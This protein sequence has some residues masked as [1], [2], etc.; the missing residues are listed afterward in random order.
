MSDLSKA[1]RDAAW[2][3]MQGPAWRNVTYA[4]LREA[5]PDTVMRSAKERVDR[6]VAAVLETLARH[7]DPVE[8]GDGSTSQALLANTELRRLAAEVFSAGDRTPGS[9]IEK[10]DRR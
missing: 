7:C 8:V 2:A 4:D 3:E 10:G 1:L 9:M 6:T 5:D